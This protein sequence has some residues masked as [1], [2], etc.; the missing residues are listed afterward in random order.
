MS[1][2][3]IVTG[4]IPGVI[5]EIV[6]LHAQYYSTHWNFS[7]YFEAKVATE[8]ASYISRYDEKKDHIFS[9]V[10]NK[11]IFGGLSI[12]NS[13]ETKNIAHLRWFILSTELR[14]QGLGN[15]LMRQA[16]AFCQRRKYES[17]Y[18][19]TFK[20]LDAAIYLYK[21][22]GFCLTKESIGRQWG[23]EVTEQ[24]FEVQLAAQP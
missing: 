21:K 19:W 18:L 3:E 13:S 22:Y 6:Q 16:I 4:Y 17:I 15:Q 5:G 1:D 2:Y 11:K 24:R 12:D 8:L 20:G 23:A 10:K 9:V 7:S 14:G